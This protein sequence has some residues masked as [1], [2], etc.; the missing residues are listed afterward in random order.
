MQT[1]QLLFAALLIVVLTV[2][3]VLSQRMSL[4]CPVLSLCPVCTV[5]DLGLLKQPLD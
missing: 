1:H 2:E 4:A 3:V 5:V